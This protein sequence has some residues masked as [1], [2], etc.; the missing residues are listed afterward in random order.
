MRRQSYSQQRRSVRSGNLMGIAV[1]ILCACSPSVLAQWTQPDA[2]GNINS[3]NTGNVGVGTTTP[4]AK[5]TVSNN[6]QSA[7]AGQ[8]GTALHVIG[9]NA[10][11]VRLLVDAFGAVTPSIDMR[12]AN[13][14]SLS[15]TA[16][17][18]G[19]GIGQITW[20]R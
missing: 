17:L 8:T 1:I 5:L 4:P 2:S 10:T 11:P 9:A 13:N 6:G 20:Q 3:T 18:S 7:P 15:R 19:D 16:L 14:T 12:R